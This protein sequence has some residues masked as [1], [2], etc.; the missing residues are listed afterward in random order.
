MW[1]KVTLGEIT[2]NLDGKRIPLNSAQ[3][4]KKAKQK[5]YPYIGA[6]N[7]LE[8][9]DEYIFDEKILCVAEDG[10]S[11]GAQEKCANIY[12][13]KCWVNN[14]AHVLIENGKANLEFLCF[15]LN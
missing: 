11:W 8:Y 7:I 2:K 13:Q 6:N 3:R 14:H 12:N 15:F 9:I 4:A 10:G 5:L 1:E